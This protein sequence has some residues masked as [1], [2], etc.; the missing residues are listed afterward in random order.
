MAKPLA[1]A[2]PLMASSS[3]KPTH[4]CTTITIAQGEGVARDTGDNPRQDAVYA[5][6]VLRKSEV[7]RRQQVQHTKNERQILAEVDHI[8]I[9]P[10]RC[11]FQTQDK[12]FMVTDYCP[13]GELFFHLK[14]MRRFTESMMRFYAAEVAEA[15]Y[16]LHHKG[17][18]YRDLKPENILLDSEGHVKLIDFGLS[19]MN[20]TPQDRTSTFCGTPEYLAPEMLLHKQQSSGYGL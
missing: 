15:I 11:A 14:R 5:I 20:A 6:K 2:S 16:Y 18:L 19:K 1:A 3:S 13:G 10:L 17:I 7:E 8:Y 12:L 4:E 9:L